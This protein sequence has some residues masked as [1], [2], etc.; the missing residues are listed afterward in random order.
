MK[1]KR[2]ELLEPNKKYSFKIIL[3]NKILH[4]TGTLIF[5]EGSFFSFVDKYN[6]QLVYNIGCLA[7]YEE[8]GK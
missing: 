5:V 4:Y 7:S 3:A 8:L 2:T 6:K 1:V